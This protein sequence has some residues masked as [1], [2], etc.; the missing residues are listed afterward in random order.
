MENTAII[1]QT[2]SGLRPSA[3]RR[4]GQ[5]KSFA[6]CTCGTG[7]DGF[8]NHQFL[9]VWGYE[10]NRG[11]LERE[12]IHSLSNLCQ[13]YQLPL[14][15]M[16][17]INFPQNIYCSWQTIAGLLKEIDPDLSCMIIQDRGKRATLATAKTYGLGQ[18]L[19]YIPVRA[20]WNWAC[21]AQQ[22]H[23]AELVTVIF[24]YL[25]QVV[26]I[27][28]YGD[29]GTFIG[30]Q[31]DTLYQWM[32]DSEEDDDDENKA[33]RE[34]Q[35]DTLYELERAGNHILRLIQ[36]PHQL[37]QLYSV[38][39]GFHHRDK[40]EL[41]WELLGIEFLQLYRRYPKRSLNDCTCP[42]LLFPDGDE[43]ISPEQY[44]GFYWSA[45]D[46]FADELDE[47]INCTFQEIAVM[48][49]PVSVQVFDKMPASPNE[50]FDFENR[51]FD[52]MERLKELLM[53]YDHEEEHYGT[54]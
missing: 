46:C 19:F 11:R 8:L 37:K 34:H 7:R 43:R 53:Q 29:N 50:A 33:Y 12:Y 24:A 52:L 27:P 3:G 30:S 21:C 41:E 16:T 4:R 17:E 36:N 13:Y 15:E 38:V 23:I 10:G 31:Y 44:T 40:A 14:P 9:P 54:V 39:T 5:A 18:D 25:Y 32:M 6:E 22:Q 48:D 49:E 47:L 45:Y 2:G 28:F 42:D 26:G 51:L 1:R 20:Y 35:E